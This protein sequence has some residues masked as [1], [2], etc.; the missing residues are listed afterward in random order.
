MKNKRRQ[1]NGETPLSRAV[2]HLVLIAASFLAFGPFLWMFLT[3]IK[4]YEET[5]QIPMK[6][7]RRLPSG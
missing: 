4:T 2:T 6:F 3:S 5:I 1:L 7:C